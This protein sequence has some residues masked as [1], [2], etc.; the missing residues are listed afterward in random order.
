MKRNLKIM[1]STIA[2]QHVI[3]YD[4]TFFHS[5]LTPVTHYSLDFTCHRKKIV[6]SILKL[7]DWI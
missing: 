2:F 5:K 7:E 1:L 6:E 3:R 4:F